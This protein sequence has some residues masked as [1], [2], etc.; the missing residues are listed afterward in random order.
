MSSTISNVDFPVLPPEAA[1]VSLPS[2]LGVVGGELLR[3]DVKH[4]PMPG[5]GVMA[6]G[7]EKMGLAKANVSVDEEGIKRVIGVLCHGVGPQRG[8]PC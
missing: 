8:Q 1:E 4:V 7:M 3:P 6:D 5:P 2:R